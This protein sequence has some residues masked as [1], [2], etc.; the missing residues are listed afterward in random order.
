MSN[1]D[2]F[3]GAVDVVL[4]DEQISAIKAQYEYV[5]SIKLNFNMGDYQKIVT[6]TSFFGL[7]TDTH[8]A[9]D[10]GA[11]NEHLGDFLYVYDWGSDDTSSPASLNRLGGALAE[12]YRMSLIGHALTLNADH[13]YVFNKIFDLDPLIDNV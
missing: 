10:L 7:F 2:R 4:T 1:K 11:A 8:I 9:N 5:L 13:A 12:L 6:K 3:K